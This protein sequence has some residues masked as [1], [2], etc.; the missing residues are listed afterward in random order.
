MS[1]DYNSPF[2]HFL[3][4]IYAQFLQNNMKTF[5]KFQTTIETLL[6]HLINFDEKFNYFFR[7]I[8]KKSYS[9]HQIL[10]IAF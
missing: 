6:H 7:R 8:N 5:F 4:L 2:E 1:S 10:C 3:Q 9:I